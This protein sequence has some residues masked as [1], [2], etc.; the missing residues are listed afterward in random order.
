MLKFVF[1]ILI[2]PL[3]LPI[4]AIYEYFILFFVGE[5]AYIFAYRFVGNLIGDGIVYDKTMAST[6]H[7]IVRIAVYGFMWGIIRIGIEIYNMIL[8]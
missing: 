3:G 2:S 4:N 8:V 6:T 5:V 7:W 1:N